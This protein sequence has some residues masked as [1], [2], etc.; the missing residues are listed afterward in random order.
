MYH[1]ALTQFPSSASSSMPSRMA[2]APTARTLPCWSLLGSSR[3]PY[4]PGQEICNKSG[5]VRSKTGIEGTI[6]D[7]VLC[8]TFDTRQLTRI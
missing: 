5:Q 1:S 3:N 7:Y 2:S 8:Y 6:L 4:V